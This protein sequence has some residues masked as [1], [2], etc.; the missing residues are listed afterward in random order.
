ML[1]RITERIWY[2]LHDDRTDR[3]N[4]GYVR[5]DRLALMVDAGASPGHVALFLS[6]LD[7][8]GLPHPRVVALTH[9][10]WDHTYG[11]EALCARTGAVVLASAL[12]GRQLDA[13]ATWKWT[14]E[15]VQ[16]RLDRGEESAFCAEMM[17]KEYGADLAGVRV[18]TPDILFEERLTVALGGVTCEAVRVG[19]PHA[20]ESV[21]CFVREERV[22]FLG[23]AAGKALH[24]DPAP[25][26]QAKVRDLMER[27]R[28]LD[29][30]LC[31]EGHWHHEPR[32][33]TL[34]YLEAEATG[35]TQE[36]EDNP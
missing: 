31:V 3:P 28:A 25:V 10:H 24:P 6:E 34:R 22:A 15:A 4:L 36:P 1:E 26:Y 32:A 2:L 8:V 18:R 16:G 17:R 27:V 11:L 12:T 23:D 19:G 5:G 14:D 9:S 35:R 29:V 7:R 33:E 20:E 13:M 21:V 30:A